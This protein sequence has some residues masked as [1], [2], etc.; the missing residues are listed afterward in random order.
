MLLHLSSDLRAASRFATLEIQNCLLYSDLA[1]SSPKSPLPIRSDD[2]C[3]RSAL[4][5]R[6]QGKINIIDD[7]S[8]QKKTMPG[9]TDVLRMSAWEDCKKHDSCFRVV[10]ALM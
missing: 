1:R 10:T 8:K 9:M 3:A 5:D 2:E 6:L 4:V 7:H